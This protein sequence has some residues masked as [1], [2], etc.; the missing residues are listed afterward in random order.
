MAKD[1]I[2]EIIDALSE[3]LVD[4]TVPKN[5][6]SIIDNII[7]TLKENVE[8]SIKVNKALHKLEEI[9]DDTNLQSYTR[10]QLWNI[11][12]MLEKI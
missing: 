10:T 1:S 2:K 11:S 9:T 3:L 7:N 4:S 6:K 5:T 8:I 12:S